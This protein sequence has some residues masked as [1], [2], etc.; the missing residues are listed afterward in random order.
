MAAKAYVLFETAVGKSKEIVNTLKKTKNITS[1]DYVTGSYD[2]IAILETENL[3]DIGESIPHDI[4][5]LAGIS[6]T[7]T[8]LSLRLD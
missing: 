3:K 4:H 8:C 7:A 6:R 1:A 2:V 5:S